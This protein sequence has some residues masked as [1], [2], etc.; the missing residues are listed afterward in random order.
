[1]GFYLLGHH[2][3]NRCPLLHTRR[4]GRHYNIP[5][6]S[7]RTQS[8]KTTCFDSLTLRHNSHRLLVVAVAHVGD[9]SVDHLVGDVR[10]RPGSM[11]RFADHTAGRR[12]AAEAAPW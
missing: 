5:Y 7:V 11:S 8:T 9:H 2:C 6:Y 12:T 10:S 4:A 3:N 1:M